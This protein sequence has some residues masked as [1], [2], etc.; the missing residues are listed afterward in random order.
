MEYAR[1]HMEYAAERERMQDVLSSFGILTVDDL[2]SAL[3]SAVTTVEVYD[4]ENRNRLL[5]SM[6]NINR[7]KLVGRK[8][9]FMFPLER[10][11]AREYH[12]HGTVVFEIGRTD[13]SARLYTDA[14]LK[15][16]LKL[17]AFQP[18]S[19]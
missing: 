14:P 4:A 2:R 15:N 18:V 11:S 13:L 19:A 8:T 17:D 10:R 3:S 5:G 16:L 12:Y 6:V 9:V 7:A 1:T